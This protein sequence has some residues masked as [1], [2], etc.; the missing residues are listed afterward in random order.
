MGFEDDIDYNDSFET[1]V[2]DLDSGNFSDAPKKFSRRELREAKKK[3]AEKTA[4]LPKKKKG[5]FNRHERLDDD[6]SLSGE[7]LFDPTRSTMVSNARDRSYDYDSTGPI[8]NTNSEFSYLFDPVDDDETEDDVYPDESIYSNSD[9]ARDMLAG[10]SYDEE[11]DGDSPEF[12][13]YFDGN[14]EVRPPS[15]FSFKKHKDEKQDFDDLPDIEDE[16]SADSRPI[17]VVPQPVVKNDADNDSFL[18]ELR[19]DSV[20]KPKIER[21]PSQ[22]I[23]D[24]AP[25][26]YK[27][28]E[29]EESDMSQDTE[30]LHQDFMPYPNMGMY[31]TY[32]MQPMNQMMGY[33]VVIPSA[34]QTQNS[35]PY[36]TIPI[37]YPMPMPMPY[38]MYPQGYYPQYP[39]YAPYA[40]YPP[41]AAPDYYG[42]YVP[43]GYDDRCNNR[44]N[45][46]YDDRYDSRHDSRYDD[47]YDGRRNS[48]YDDRVD[49][50]SRHYDDGREN[51]GDS[52]YD[53]RH[54]EPERK[55]FPQPPYQPPYPQ[56]DYSAGN[57]FARSEEEHVAQPVKATE[58]SQ[59]YNA[60]M[61][62]TQPAPEPIET[63]VSPQPVTTSESAPTVSNFNSLDF[64]FNKPALDTDKK[65]ETSAFSSDFGLD[66]LEN[67]LSDDTD[68]TL[69]FGSTL[70]SDNDFKIEFENPMGQT[71]GSVSE[72]VE[73]GRPRGGRFK[74]RR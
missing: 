15:K 36:Q 66:G 3:N 47:R 73:E 62:P 71:G 14:A 67:D 33:P 34:G 4:D 70:S 55:T 32:P 31:P 50:R 64:T 29:S 27:A 2:A 8:R 25:T 35:V 69:G 56:A 53:D 5:L 39:Q 26:E 72:P 43:S 24:Y 17:K 13:K 18:P 48:Q 23:Q 61:Y 49:E 30:D 42:R 74:K 54:R 6:D 38:P 22:P 44:R 20:F 21:Q 40:P 63:V 59:A 65:T 11:R 45:S 10:L 7:H 12:D 68:N 16:S 1:D 58:P 57:E 41:Y 37:P 51:R 46:R 52:H 19:P 60:P 9:N 28:K